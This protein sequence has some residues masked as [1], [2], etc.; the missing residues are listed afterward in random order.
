MP[1]DWGIK[2]L[3][4]FISKGRPEWMQEEEFSSICKIV[5]QT[6]TLSDESNALRQQEI[7]LSSEKLE[8]E[9]LMKR[10]LAQLDLIDRVLTNP[11]S[12]EKIEDYDQTF[13]P[14][15]RKNLELVASLL[16]TSHA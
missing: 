10:V 14:G 2:E 8:A 11:N 1:S 6:K 5:S 7:K 12:I 13:A 3:D 4:F 9:N 16:K 15:N